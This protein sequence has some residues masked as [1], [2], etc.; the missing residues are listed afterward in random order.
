MKQMESTR[1]HREGRREIKSIHH[2]LNQ[3]DGGVWIYFGQGCGRWCPIRFSGM[4][5]PDAVVFVP[6]DAWDPRCDAHNRF[7]A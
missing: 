2:R 5:R 7:D 4:G 3:R 1:D 6:V